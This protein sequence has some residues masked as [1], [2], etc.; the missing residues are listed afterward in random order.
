V[1]ASDIIRAQV[2]DQKAVQA[3]ED[4]L[5][6]G[7]AMVAA[8][9]KAKADAQAAQDA[10]TA[11]AVRDAEA[12]KNCDWNPFSGNSC[13]GRAVGAAANTANQAWQA[14]GGQ[15]VNYASNHLDQVAML[16]TIITVATLC[17]GGGVATAGVVAAACAGF[18]GGAAMGGTM[19]AASYG[20]NCG[21]NCSLGGLAGSTIGGAFVGGVSGAAT[22]GAMSWL[23]GG[24]AV[25]ADAGAD[26]LADGGADLEAGAVNPA[27]SFKATTTV[28][29]PSGAIAIANLKVGDQVLAYDTKTGQTGPHTVEAVMAKTDPV[30]EHLQMDSGLIET[31]PNHPFFTMDRGWVEAGNL[32]P[33]EKVRTDTGT[34]ATVVSFTLESTPT[35]MWDI[36]VDGA[37]DFFVGTGA[38]LVHNCDVFVP[39][40][41]GNLNYDAAQYVKANMYAPSSEFGDLP[42]PDLTSLP[43]VVRFGAVVIVGGGTVLSSISGG[44]PEEQVD[45]NLQWRRR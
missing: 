11:K 34:D 13:A 38:V 31:T 12:A 41:A 14:T 10:A 20:M 4:Q 17:I 6:A 5:D 23:G 24:G 28:A 40:E 15:V 2:A 18:I 39:F 45:H 27:C 44:T 37:H 1:A 33:G 25:A 42:A 26:A 19:G 36:T 7:A 35:T 16:A 29:T 43:K 30:V 8:A 21:S 32:K 9:A 3:A 22:G